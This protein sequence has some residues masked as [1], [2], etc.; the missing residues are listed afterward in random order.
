M[1]AL[2]HAVFVLLDP[3]ANSWMQTPAGYDIVDGRFFPRDWPEIIFNPSFPFRLAHT[4]AAFYVTT[5]FVVLGVGAYH[6]AQA[7]LR[8]GAHD[9]AAGAGF[10]IIFVPLQ[11]VLGDQHGLNTLEHQ[12]A[13]LAAMEGALGRRQG[14]SRSAV[15]HCPISRASATSARS[16]FRVWAASILTHSWDGAVKGLKDFPADQRPPVAIVYFAFRIMVGVA[17]LMLATVVSAWCCC[18]NGGSIS[19]VGIS[20]GANSAPASASSR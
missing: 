10:L 8:R 2:G 13:K 19:S 4:V 11:M 17:M 6:R 15:R 20:D 7:D 12:P 16:Q 9:A 14:R 3:A 1:V 5:A 18:G